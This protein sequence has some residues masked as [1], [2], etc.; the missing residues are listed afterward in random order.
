M[1]T[2][3]IILFL[4]LTGQVALASEVKIEIAD[5]PE[6][7]KPI[8]GRVEFDAK[9]RSISQILS[10]EEPKSEGPAFLIFTA[11]A[12][13]NLGK[14]LLWIDAEVELSNGKILTFRRIPFGLQSKGI[15]ADIRKLENVEI[16]FKLPDE[17]KPTDPKS[18][19]VQRLRILSAAFK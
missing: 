14:R 8:L 3:Q 12:K 11:S 7:Q 5:A 9:I 19:V 6:W 1:K 16:E 17:G 2:L 4:I 13:E 15:E 10:V 18:L